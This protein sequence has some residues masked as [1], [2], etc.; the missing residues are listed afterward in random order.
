M[1]QHESNATK[2][3]SANLAAPAPSVPIGA[4]QQKRHQRK[5]VRQRP[6]QPAQ[7]GQLTAPVKDEPCDTDDSNVTYRSRT[8]HHHQSSNGK[9]TT[10]LLTSDGRTSNDVMND[11]RASSSNSSAY[12]WL[13]QAFH[14]LLPPQSQLGGLETAMQHNSS[15]PQSG[16]P[17]TILFS[18]LA[19]QFA[20]FF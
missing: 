3:V 7:Q 10:H 4:P 19:H 5:P 9:K 13:Q 14:S 18:R 20:S 11:P 8:D 6:I 12:K 15:S 1:N 2:I 17:Q 16:R